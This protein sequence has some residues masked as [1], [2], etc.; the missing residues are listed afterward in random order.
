MTPYLGVARRSVTRCRGKV[1]DV[2]ARSEVFGFSCLPYF[3]EEGSISTSEIIDRFL[4]TGLSEPPLGSF[5][6]I[7]RSSDNGD[8]EGRT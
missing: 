8:V 6:C 7:S 1:H 5:I 3:C 2:F 4:L